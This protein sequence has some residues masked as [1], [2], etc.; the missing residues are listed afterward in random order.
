MNRPLCLL[1]LSV[2]LL[3]GCT[4][5]KME[6]G[7]ARVRVLAADADVSGCVLR[8]EIGVS[9]KDRVGLYDR[10]ALKV[11]DELETMARNEAL[12][13][14]ADAV[15]PTSEPAL[16]EQRFSAY[17]CGASMPRRQ[18]PSNTAP[19]PKAQPLQMEEAE[20]FPVR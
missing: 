19:A 5:V 4:W 15:K 11:R 13:L 12:D 14:D 8:G 7:A 9:V 6:P 1:A 18:A 2:L 3:G 17:R 10:N 16:G 20:T